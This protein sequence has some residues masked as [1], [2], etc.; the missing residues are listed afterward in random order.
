M[1]KITITLIAMAMAATAQADR[2]FTISG[3][4]LVNILIGN[5]VEVGSSSSDKNVQRIQFAAGYNAGSFEAGPI[6]VYS[7]EDDGT[8]VTKTSGL[9]AY[10]RYNFVENKKGVGIVPYGQLMLVSATTK[11]GGLSSDVFSYSLS[12]GATFFPINDVIGIN[13]FLAYRDQKTSTNAADVKEKGFQ[14]G[15]SFNLYFN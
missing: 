11:V 10:G 1:K 7:N 13:G 15:T 9:G 3:E 2:A 5:K 8:T 6:L 12:G 14:L 4:S